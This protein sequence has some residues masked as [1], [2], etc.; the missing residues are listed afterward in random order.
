[1]TLD[2]EGN[3]TWTLNVDKTFTAVTD[4]ITGT[5]GEDV[6]SSTG[7]LEDGAMV[8]Y[9]L[10]TSIIETNTVVLPTIVSGDEIKFYGLN[11]QM[12]ANESKSITILNGTSEPTV[13]DGDNRN[14]Y[15][16]YLGNVRY[17][18]FICNKIR[19]TTLTI[20]QLSEIRFKDSNGNYFEYPSDT[21]ATASA[22][23]TSSKENASKLIDGNTSTKYCSTSYSSPCTITFDLG[24]EA[25]DLSTYST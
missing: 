13:S 17:I 15:L 16:K 19:N 1:M 2:S 22:T 25:L 11:V 21:I 23:P 8:L 3:V 12:N 4:G 20:I 6:L 10:A 14:M 5:V 18:K 24:S 9:P 7:V